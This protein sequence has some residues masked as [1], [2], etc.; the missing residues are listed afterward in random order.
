VPKT[1]NIELHLNSISCGAIT[2]DGI[3]IAKVT[4]DVTIHAKPGSGPV[5]QLELRPGQMAI[6]LDSAHVAIDDATRELLLKL[7]WT[8]PPTS[9]T[10]WGYGY[11][12]SPTA[13]VGPVSELT[14]RRTVDGDYSAV[15][16][17]RDLVDGEPGP[18]KAVETR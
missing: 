10:E 1:D 14:A 17:R 2:L 15:L 11:V 9:D 6:A 5:I 18:W 3:E 12:D 4:T 16:H 7:G 8:E 13:V